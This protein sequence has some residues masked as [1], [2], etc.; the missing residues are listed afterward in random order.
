[1]R[2]LDKTFYKKVPFWGGNLSPKWVIK[3]PFL[4][5]IVPNLPLYGYSQNYKQL[6]I[7]L[8]QISDY[9]LFINI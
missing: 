6:S 8:S 7:N 4:L 1:M 9:K 5:F 2:Y 3:R